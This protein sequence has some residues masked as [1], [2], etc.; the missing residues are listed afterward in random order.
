VLNPTEFRD[1]VSGRK[2]GWG[3]GLLRGA[4]RC[5][6]WP[7][8]WG[9]GWRNRSYDQGRRA[10][11]RVE[12]PVVSVGNLTLGGTGKTPLVAYLARWYRQREVRVSIVSR[13]YGAGES[14]TNDEALEL[15]QQLPDVPHVQ[16]ADR[17]AAAQLAIEELD[18]QL[19]LLDD[20]FQ[21]RRL[22]R[23][24]DLVL[25][26]ALDPFG[27]DYLFPRGMLREPVTSLA[28][29]D[30]VALSRSNL[31][32]AAKRDA[33]RKQVERVAPEAL[34][35][36]TSHIPRHLLNASS[37]RQPWSYLAGKRV[38][39]FCGLGNPSGFR[40]TL[41]HCG[42]GVVAWR[43]FPDHHRYTREDVTSLTNWGAQER[44]DALI[45]THKDLVKLGVD[46][47]GSCPLW[48][49]AIELE[50]GEGE[51][52]LSRMLTAMLPPAT[53]PLG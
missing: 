38:G 45:C 29:A 51:E 48:A 37:Q 19:I 21:H 14:G 44:L 2:Q 30:V 47:L 16:D 1:L 53:E 23:D 34:W 52:P 7:Y 27:L 46:S 39:A 28:R 8:G 5:A 36:E 43:E 20:G 10:I 15:E 25:L 18:T 12:R 50:V 13:G 33:I 32:D 26:D 49:L 3:A 6:A 17:V 35:I 42:L 31:I 22:D 24:I 11:I 9:V 4:L 41:A 40:Q